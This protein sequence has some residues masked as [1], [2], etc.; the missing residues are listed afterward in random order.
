MA[1][2]K[3]LVLWQA[4]LG[5]LFA[6]G[7][8]AGMGSM[9][10]GGDGGMGMSHDF[11]PA[12]PLIEPAPWPGSLDHPVAVDADPA[13]GVVAID[14]TA[15]AAEVEFLP[16]HPTTAWTFD[17]MVP[18]PTIEAR[19]G[20]TLVV[21]FRNELS[22]PTSIHWHGLRV[23]N[24]M[25]GAAIHSRPVEPGETFEYRFPLLDAGTFWY[26]P[27]HRSN[28]EVGRGLYGV[29]VVRDPSAETIATRAEETLVLS[30]V[31]VDANTGQLASSSD[32]RAMMMGP[33]GNLLLVNGR[34]SNVEVAVRAGEARRWRVVNA[35][36]SRYFLLQQTGGTMVR[37]GGE[38]LLAR[39]EPVGGGG[40]LLAP[41]MRADLLVWANAPGSTVVVRAAPYERAMGSGPSQAADLV[42]LVADATP[43]ATPPDIPATLRSIPALGTP[44]ATREVVLGETMMM[45]GGSS[46][47]SFTINGRS[48][49]DVPEVEPSAGSIEEWNLVNDTDMDHPFHLHGFSFQVAGSDEVRDT[50]NVAAR[51]QIRVRIDFDGRDGA[52][53]EWLYHC[54]ILEHAEN[55][56]TAVAL[57]R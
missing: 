35:A 50:I 21:R 41:G 12:E 39:P 28:E 34:P 49:P 43:A 24:G 44:A 31:R 23:P 29:I 56:M 27:H 3:T 5:A 46:M 14:L 48:F 25:D 38:Q 4:I 30:D 54:H 1:T 55:G 15:R 13:P 37:I 18:G 32:T 7:C 45:M 33:E 6:T 42:R 53:G 19:V 47:M 2:R 9:P 11:G 22:A 17:G 40:L 20:D 57:V 10:H 51:E 8:G 26:H 36:T 16:G 52:K